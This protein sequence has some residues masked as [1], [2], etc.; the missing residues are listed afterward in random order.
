MLRARIVALL[1]AWLVWAAVGTETASPQEAAP[2]ASLCPGP[3][4]AELAE[5]G[6]AMETRIAGKLVDAGSDEPLAGFLIRL[7]SGGDLRA[8]T[9]GQG[10]FQLDGVPPGSYRMRVGGVGYGEQS[11]CVMIPPDREVDLVMALHPEPIPVDP[12]AVRV[13][14]SRPLWLVR[15]G[16]YRRMKA[17]GGVFI[18]EQEIEEQAPSRLSEMFRDEPG[19]SVADGNPSPMQSLKPTHPPPGG[20]GRPCPMSDPELCRRPQDTGTCPIQF[21]VDGR[22]VP[23]ILGVDTFHPEDVAGIEAYFHASEIPPRFNVGRAAC[24]VVNVWLKM[25]PRRPG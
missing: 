20:T 19:V 9:D 21:L 23:L 13:E 10:N 18:T 6:G 24:G 2:D 22:A 17:G 16:F 3:T 11:S 4:P 8:A 14:G 25:H 1:G 7:G 5:R 12:L 15:E